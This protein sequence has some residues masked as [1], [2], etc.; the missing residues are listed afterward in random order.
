M[1]G[2]EFE[3][4]EPKRKSSRGESARNTTLIIILSEY[5]PRRSILYHSLILL[6]EYPPMKKKAAQ[7]RTENFDV[8]TVVIFISM[9]VISTFEPWSNLCNNYF[10]SFVAASQLAFPS[11]SSIV[12]KEHQRSLMLSYIQKKKKEE[13]KQYSSLSELTS[14]KFNLLQANIKGVERK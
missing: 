5:Q 11:R 2:Y 10:Y 13:K 3:N 6:L 9:Q 1:I 12:T 8:N 4:K 14:I 7:Y